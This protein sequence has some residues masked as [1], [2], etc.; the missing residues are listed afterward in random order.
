MGITC[1]THPSTDISAESV[2]FWIRPWLQA[3]TSGKVDSFSDA[4]K[5]PEWF[6]G[7]QLLCMQLGAE[8]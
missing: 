1:V 6:N 7:S 8:F 4:R 3:P 5:L 2:A